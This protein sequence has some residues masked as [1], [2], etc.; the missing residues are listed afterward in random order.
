MRH[1]LI[2]EL[3]YILKASDMKVIRDDLYQQSTE[4]IVV[5]P[6]GSKIVY[7]GDENVLL[8]LKSKEK[9]V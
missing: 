9:E 6:P 3:P 8:V 5:L 4:G 1:M 2:V 7:S